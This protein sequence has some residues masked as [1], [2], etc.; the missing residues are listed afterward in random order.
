M[1]I[2]TAFT[3][4]LLAGVVAV[5]CVPADPAEAPTAATVEAR[6]PTSRPPTSPPTWGATVG[7]KIATIDGKHGD[8]TY[9]RRADFLT[10]R[11]AGWCAG[12]ISAERVGDY[13]TKS[14]EL[15]RDNYGVRVQVLEVLEGVQDS[16]IGI[17]SG[18]FDCAEIFAAFTIL[19]GQ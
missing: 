6:R 15:L 8:S 19:A 5:G 16:T 14:W 11:I 4:A 9:A 1:R 3:A 12:P 13:A 2:L 7:E 17:E 10:E 18:V